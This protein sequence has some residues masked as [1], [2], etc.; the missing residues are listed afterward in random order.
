MIPWLIPRN[1]INWIKNEEEEK[2]DVD[3]VKHTFARVTTGK[4]MEDANQNQYKYGG[5]HLLL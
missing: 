5:H 4:T 2:K 1:N 3:D